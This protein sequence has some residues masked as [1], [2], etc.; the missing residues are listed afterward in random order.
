MSVDGDKSA[1]SVSTGQTDRGV[2]DGK[3]AELSTYTSHLLKSLRAN[4]ES[5]EMNIQKLQ[6]DMMSLK[7]VSASLKDTVN[8]LEAELAQ[9][10]ADQAND[11]KSLEIKVRE[12]YGRIVDRESRDNDLEVASEAQDRIRRAN[13]VL[14]FNVPDSAAEMPCVAYLTVR[15]LLSSMSL[16][17]DLCTSAMRLG[18][19]HCR[20]RPILAVLKS[21]AHVHMVIKAKNRLRLLPHWRNVWIG[22]DMTV[23]QRSRLRESRLRTNGAIVNNDRSTN[24]EQ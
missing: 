6:S 14:I 22:E 4:I 19:H 16:P 8:D 1:D 5:H 3:P 10:K 15:D 2:K 21:N 7:V 18:Y 23:N 11:V 24:R 20:P 17:V 12:I 13:N 9:V